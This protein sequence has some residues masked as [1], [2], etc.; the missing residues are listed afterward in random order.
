MS[1]RFLEPHLCRIGEV[2][3]R[4]GRSVPS[5]RRLVEKGHIKARVVRGERVFIRA[6]VEAYAL[7]HGGEPELASHVAARMMAMGRSDFEILAEVDIA[8]SSLAEV[9]RLFEAHTKAQTKAAP[10]PAP[11][12]RTSDT[13]VPPPTERRTA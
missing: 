6:D 5:I 4:L 3:R 1:A 7:R 10:P 2:S 11:V 9:R 13:L 8:L 12:S